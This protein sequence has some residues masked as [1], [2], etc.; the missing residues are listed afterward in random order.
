M[1]EKWTSAAKNK[2]I[3]IMQVGALALPDA[4]ELAAHAESLG[5][6]AIATIPSFHF[7]RSCKTP[8]A[9]IALNFFLIAPY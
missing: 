8:G 1:A 4:I 3:I 9:Y 6:D 5:V 2:L 7:A